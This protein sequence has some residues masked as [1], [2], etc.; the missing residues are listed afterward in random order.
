[1]N[2]STLKISHTA[3]AIVL[4]VDSNL[5]IEC[6]CTYLLHMEDVFLILVVK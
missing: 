1:M 6:Y 4:A 2:E 5:L 3:R